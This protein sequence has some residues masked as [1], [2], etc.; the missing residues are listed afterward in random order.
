MLINIQTDAY[1]NILTKKIKAHD[2]SKNTCRI[3]LK[4]N[5]GDEVIFYHNCGF[6]H[7]DKLLTL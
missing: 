4:F 1:S 3:L 5:I 2:K 6:G 7:K